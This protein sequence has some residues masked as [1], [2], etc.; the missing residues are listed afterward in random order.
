[1]DVAPAN[2]ELFDLGGEAV[3]AVEVAVAEDLKLV[4]VVAA[5]NRAKKVHHRVTPEVSRDISQAEAFPG[6]NRGSGGDAEGIG[7]FHR[8][9]S[10]HTVQGEDMLWRKRGMEVQVVE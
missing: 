4:A 10:P 8:V 1:G 2:V 7:R 9:A 3:F 6:S 5:Q